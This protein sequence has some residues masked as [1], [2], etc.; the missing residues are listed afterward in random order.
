MALLNMGKAA[1]QFPYRL[2]KG[3]PLAVG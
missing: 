1:Q 2:P 3:C